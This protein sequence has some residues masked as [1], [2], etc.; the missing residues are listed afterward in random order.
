MSRGGQRS[1]HG[2]D[3][4]EVTRSPAD[5]YY[6]T[7]MTATRTPDLDAL[8]AAGAQLAR[9][10][11]QLVPSNGRALEFFHD[12]LHRAQDQG[13]RDVWGCFAAGL[14]TEVEARDVVMA[15]FATWL[16]YENGVK[17]PS[18]ETWN[19][20]DLERCFE[21]AILGRPARDA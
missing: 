20:P 8:V 5:A 7:T 16:S 9:A 19:S 10:I 3:V 6:P 17:E 11:G 21:Q 14:I 15:R 2:G 4:G 18:S 1:R 13:G 12:V